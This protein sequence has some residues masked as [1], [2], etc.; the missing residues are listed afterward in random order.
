MVGR[1]GLR[2]LRLDGRLSISEAPALLC[3]VCLGVWV[4]VCVRVRVRF[5]VSLCAAVVLPLLVRGATWGRFHWRCC[6]GCFVCVCGWVC[7]VSFGV[8]LCVCC[9]LFSSCSPPSS[10]CRESCYVFVRTFTNWCSSPFPPLIPWWMNLPTTMLD[11]HSQRMITASLFFFFP[12]DCFP[13]LCV[14]L[15]CSRWLRHL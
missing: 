9:C 11:A 7:S 14:C 4:C 15:F 12:S 5:G 8:G 1:P 3:W 2:H 13:V 6:V 10:S